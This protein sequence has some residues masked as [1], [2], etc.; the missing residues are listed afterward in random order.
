MNSRMP[1]RAERRMARARGVTLIELVVVVAIAGILAAMAMP[2]L[3]SLVRDQRIKTAAGDVH[4]SIIYA[5][6]EAIKRNQNVAM[7]ARNADGNGCGNITNWGVGWIVFVDADGN[8]FPGA[9]ADILKKQDAFTGVTV[10]GTGT[11]LS[12]QRDGRLA[13]PLAANFVAGAAGATSSR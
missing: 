1:F 11:N 9:V 8:G 5:R 13:A 12:Y 4:A 7:C 2:T 6:S 3:G 10:T